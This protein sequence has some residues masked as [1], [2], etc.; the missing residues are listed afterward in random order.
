LGVYLWTVPKLTV[1][2]Y[3]QPGLPIW[4]WCNLDADPH[5]KWPSGPVANTIHRL[6]CMLCVK[7]KQVINMEN[8][9]VYEHGLTA[10]LHVLS[11]L[12]CFLVDLNHPTKYLES[13][14][15]TWMVTWICMW[16]R[17]PRWWWQFNK[18]IT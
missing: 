14:W 2:V 10:V 12:L 1:W 6:L 4:Q 15:T 17:A 7:S 3:W 5:P 11:L 8:C 18:W 13:Q 16:W 9:N